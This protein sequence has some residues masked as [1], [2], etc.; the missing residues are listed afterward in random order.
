MEHVNLPINFLK[1]NF[2]SSI[3]ANVTCGLPESRCKTG[4][5]RSAVKRFSGSVVQISLL[6]EARGSGWSSERRLLPTARSPATRSTFD[7]SP[8]SSDHQATFH[9]IHGL[10]STSPTI[11]ASEACRS[12]RSL[13]REHDGQQP[14]LRQERPGG[15]R[16]FHQNC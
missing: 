3:M 16:W 2:R 13:L 12:T 6:S 9:P 14:V 8:T 1:Y 11:S 5:H 10:T 4:K 15:S 7:T